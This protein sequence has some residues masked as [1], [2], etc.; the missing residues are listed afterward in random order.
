MSS[1]LVNLVN[2]ANIDVSCGSLARSECAIR[3]RIRAWRAGML[4]SQPRSGDRHPGAG[5]PH[6]E[7]E[8]PS[9]VPFAG[10]LGDGRRQ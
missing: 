8:S 3:P 9:S 10:A 7:S 5:G 4:I 6:T 2:I 1:S